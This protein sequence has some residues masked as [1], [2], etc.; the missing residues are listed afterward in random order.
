[1][2]QIKNIK[3]KSYQI[4]EGNMSFFSIDNDFYF[5]DIKINYNK[6]KCDE[7]SYSIYKN[8]AIIQSSEDVSSIIINLENNSI[9][10]HSFGC[11]Y[12]Q[13]RNSKLLFFKSVSL[14]KSIVF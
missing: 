11:L 10:I 5:N 8:Y 7:Q 14:E 6:F 13:I 3:I 12:N 9:T 1:M 4:N 2:K